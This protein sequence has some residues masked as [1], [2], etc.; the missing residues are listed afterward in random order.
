MNKDLLFQYR[1]RRAPYRYNDTMP[2]LAGRTG[3]V[4]SAAKD[5]V[6]VWWADT[7]DSQ[8]V[9]LSMAQFAKEFFPD[10]TSYDQA[11]NLTYAKSARFLVKVQPN[12]LSRID[13]LLVKAR[14][15]PMVLG[16]TGRACAAHNTYRTCIVLEKTETEV[17]YVALTEQ[18]FQIKTRPKDKFH[19]WYFPTLF[20]SVAG[21]R[22]YQAYMPYYKASDVS[23][24]ERLNV[25]IKTLE[26]KAMVKKAA[27]QAELEELEELDSDE[28]LEEL[29]ADAE[30]EDLEE[31]EAAP[32]RRAA[33]ASAPKQK[34][35]KTP[36]ASAKSKAAATA[37]PAKGKA[38]PA[39]GKKTTGRPFQIKEGTSAGMFMTL[40]MEGKLKDDQ[41]FSKVQKKYDLDDSRRGYVKWYRNHLT[42][43]G[44]NPPPPV[45]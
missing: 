41:I 17:T 42:K 18:G 24:P 45:G 6:Q 3:L 26:D 25:L 32:A 1:F 37:A 7:P 5:K 8:L 23:L 19:E 40:I 39:A 21:I 16:H 14:E 29:E 36:P 30:D 22:L 11:M 28:Q 20:D 27:K 15:R 33:K 4:L 12:V 44:M 43:R 38:A 10:F 9:T 31:V 13:E 35:L 2:W 34:A